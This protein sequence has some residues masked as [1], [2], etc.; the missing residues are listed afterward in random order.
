MA[1]KRGNGEGSIS[2]LPSGKWRAQA[3]INGRRVGTTAATHKAAQEQLRKLL[4]DADKGLLPPVEKLTLEA[5]IARWLADV[6]Q[7][8][9][10]ASTAR[11]Y[12]DLTRLYVVPT[13]GKVKLAQLQP[14]DV[15]RL[16]GT[17]LAR[18]LAPKTVRNVH[19]ALRR[20]LQQAVDWNL[21][22]RNVAALTHPPRVARQEVAALAPEE[23]R[24]LLAAVRGDRWEALIAVALA[25]GMRFGELLGLR[26]SD[27]DLTRHTIR[28]QR[29]LQ[30]DGTFAEPKT[31]KGRRTIDLPASCMVVVKEHKRQQ[32]EERL[33]VGPAWQPGDLAFCTHEGKPLLQR[34]VFRA[35][36]AILA[37]AGLPP[38]PF[39]ALRHTAA[40]LLLVQGVHPKIVQERLGHSNIG[41]T[42]DTYSHL[43]PSMGRDAAA[44]LDALFA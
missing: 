26:W 14:G 35:F 27:V 31:A 18:G 12:A 3:T 15:Q 40:T 21:T 37:R 29:Q 7:H 17:L 34:N 33:L 9:V 24:T 13:L 43:I 38:I 44:Q 19:A 30:R 16:Y 36:K 10:R 2:Q 25:T 39:H 6:V 32:N 4:S 28:V 1:G 5:H 23:V 22:P 8:S 20:A 41:M 11:N 42:L